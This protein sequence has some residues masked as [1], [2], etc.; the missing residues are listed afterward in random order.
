MKL[1][2][3]IMLVIGTVGLLLNEFVFE[4]GRIT[5]LILAAFNLVGLVILVALHRRTKNNQPG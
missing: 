3:F 4:W 5:A 2:A 1:I